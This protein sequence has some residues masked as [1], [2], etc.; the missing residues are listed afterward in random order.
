MTAAPVTTGSGA[1]V[2]D[3]FRRNPSFRWGAGLDA[4]WSSAADFRRHLLLISAHDQADDA[5]D[6]LVALWK[7]CAEGRRRGID[8]DPI[9]HEVAALSTDVH[10]QGMG[11]TRHLIERGLEKR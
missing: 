4:T 9:V 3:V 2:R 5:R 6:E 8:I 1:E 7:L 11:T 10:H